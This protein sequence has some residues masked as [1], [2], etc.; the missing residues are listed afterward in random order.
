MTNKKNSRKAL[1]T[2]LA[3]V[4]ALVG[5]LPPAKRP[6]VLRAVRAYFGGAYW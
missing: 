3:R 6:P 2:A 5:D 1:Q 4:I